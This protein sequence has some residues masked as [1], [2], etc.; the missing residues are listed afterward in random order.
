MPLSPS[1]QLRIL[2]VCMGNICRSP[3]GECVFR[4]FVRAA[5]KAA[6]IDVDSAGTIGYHTGEPPDAR[7][8]D[9]A[10]RRGYKM[11]GAARQVRREDFDEFD[12]IIA[13]DR[14]N[15][16]DLRAQAPTPEKAA[17]LHLLTEF[18]PAAGSRVDDVPDPYYGG[19][20]GFETVLDMIEAACPALLAHLDTLAA[21][22]PQP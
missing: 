5:G 20:E 7:M 18:Q 2:F 19:P 22:A 3:A 15:L 4:H 10:R 16:R 14:Q 12:V 17:K 21:K 11:T 8:I 9:A 1:R 6:A 13:M